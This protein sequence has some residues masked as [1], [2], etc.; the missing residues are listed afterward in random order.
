MAVIIAIYTL[1]KLDPLA[2]FGSIS[3]DNLVLSI[4]FLVSTN[5]FF[6]AVD[7][8]QVV[9]LYYYLLVVLNVLFMHFYILLYFF[10]G[11]YI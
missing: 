8:V 1:Q 11:R 7:T 5:S 4:L 9:L 10:Q 3:A 6:L 2:C